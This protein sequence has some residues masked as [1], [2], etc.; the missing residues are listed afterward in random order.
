MITIK[1]T[2]FTGSACAII[3]PFGADGNVDY[4]MLKKQV[5]YQIE[6][7]TDAIVVCGTTGESAVLSTREHRQVIKSVVKYV[8]KRVPVIAGTGSNSTETAARRSYTA[9]SVGADA[10]LVVTPYYNKCSQSGLIEHYEF[11]TQQTDLPL[12]VYNVPSRTGVDIKPE[13]YRELCKIKNI[14]ATKEA[15]G[16]ISALTKTLSLCGDELDIYCGNDDQTAAFMAMGAKG[17]ISVLSNIVP[18]EIHK[19]TTLSLNSKLKESIFLQ[20][21]LLE[22]C[23][24]LFCD[25][26]P[27]PVKYAMRLME[28]DSGFYR[29]PLNDTSDINK[30]HIRACLKKYGLIS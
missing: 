5:N 8:E 7:G 15:N 14:V 17:V 30:N 6:N 26:N 18:E 16:N 21:K 27:I 10:L 24:V 25:V 11:I 1:Q 28:L 20:F 23:E 29:L 3:T 4:R 9:E 12:I 22:L 2:V 19:M 13:T